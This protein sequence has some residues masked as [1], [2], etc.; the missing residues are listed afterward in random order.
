MLAISECWISLEMCW[1]PT[2]GSVR[3]PRP[4]IRSDYIGFSEPIG[5]DIGFEDLGT[6]DNEQKD[7]EI[8]HHHLLAFYS[9]WLTS[10]F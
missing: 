1:N 6:Y 2:V 5:S 9:Y 4:G 7:D 10:F 8:V 3:I